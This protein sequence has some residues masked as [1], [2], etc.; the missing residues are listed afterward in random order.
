MRRLPPWFW[1]VLALVFG[2]TATLMALGWLRGQSQKRAQVDISMRPVVVAAKDI[3]PALALA[4]DQLVVR[5]WPQENCPQGSFA[6]LEDVTGRVTAFPFGAGEP[7]LEIKLAPQGV[8]PGLT[9]LLSPEKRAMTV[10]VDEASGVAGFL[11]PDNRV[12]VVM[13]VEKG[14]YQKDPISKVILQNLR[15]LGTGQ[16]IEKRAGDKPMVVPTVTLEVT[17][18]EG[19]RLALAMREGHISLVLRGQKDQ[20]MV[21]TAGVRTASLLQGTYPLMTNGNH[22]KEAEAPKE[23]PRRHIEVIKGLHRESVNL[24]ST[25]STS[26]P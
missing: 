1:L 25:S 7:I 9:A 17:V 2:T 11:T 16:K 24:E 20:Q 8:S 26:T 12:D 21:H 15:V 19:E 3:D 6:R 23:Q 5:H 4:Q 10:K 22:Q 14:E 13:T 18:E